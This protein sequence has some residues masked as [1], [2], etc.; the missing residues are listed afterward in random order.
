MLVTK[1]SPFLIMFSQG[2]FFRVVKSQDCVVKSCFTLQCTA[3]DSHDLFSRK[4]HLRLTGH[5]N[6][7]GKGDNTGYWHFLFPQ[8]FQNVSPYIQDCVGKV[9]TLP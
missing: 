7:V 3:V 9:S 4:H 5:G 6:I 2:F 8:C 1:G